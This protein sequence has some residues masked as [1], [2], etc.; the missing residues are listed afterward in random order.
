MRTRTNVANGISNLKKNVIT[1]ESKDIEHP[2]DISS[3]FYGR[4][5]N[6]IMGNGIIIPTTNEKNDKYNGK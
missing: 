5:G 1:V 6:K 4:N 2:S 3:K